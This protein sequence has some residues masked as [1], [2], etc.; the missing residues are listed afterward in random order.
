[1]TGRPGPLA[2]AGGTGREGR[3]LAL[4][5]AAA[6]HSVLI[7]SRREDR[8]RGTAAAVA[9][10][11]ARA[12]R[13]VAAAITGRSNAAAV[14]EARLV[15]L[16]LP[17]AAL[18]AFLAEHAGLLAGKIVVDPTVPLRLAGDRF[19]LEPVAG[20]SASA[21]VRSLAP[22]ARVVAGFKNVAASHLL[23]LD[24]PAEG[25]ILLASD[26]A[27]AKAVVAALVRDVPVLRL[28]DAGP[29]AN[30]GFLEA[31]T[32]L[33]LNLNRLHRSVTAVRILGL[34]RARPPGGEP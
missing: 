10:T 23:A 27:A 1:V 4:R 20:G 21:R 8:A 9:A 30:A 15:F 11:L 25:D 6:G 34:D 26:D 19:E 31:L 2:F 5:L 33:E 22:G 3:G 32:A 14:G 18:V 16:T 17:F 24:R 13:P 7:G 12:G 28:I 29:L